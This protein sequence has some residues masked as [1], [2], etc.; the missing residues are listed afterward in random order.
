MEFLLQIAIG[1]FLAS[2]IVSLMNS[3]KQK[4]VEYEKYQQKANEYAQLDKNKLLNYSCDQTVE[5]VCFYLQEK[6]N[7]SYD[8]A[9]KQF[10]EDELVVYA[11]YQLE[12]SVANQRVSI[13][14]FFVRAPELVDRMPEIFNTLQLNEMSD[15]YT[16]AHQL[17]LKIQEEYTKDI[18]D[19]IDELESDVENY[20][21]EKNF[22]D[23]SKELR[24]I[25]KSEAYMET[26]SSY[27]KT[28]VESF[29][30]EKK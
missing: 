24:E 20:A 1:F 16:Q 22:E 27:I 15:I 21:K 26:L 28:H 30:K 25:F 11:L 5:A 13:N 29:I 18:N 3:K 9:L 19:V 4:Q 6:C 12:I 10:N 23:Y 2:F 7:G 8:E 14:D 17:Y